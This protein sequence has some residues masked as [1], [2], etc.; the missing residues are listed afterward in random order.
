MAT[1]TKHR[2]QEE[3]IWDF[4]EVKTDDLTLSK[5]VIPQGL[6][7]ILVAH[8]GKVGSG[9]IWDSTEK[10]RVWTH[11]QPPLKFIAVKFRRFVRRYTLNEKDKKVYYDTTSF[12][13]GV[14][15]R[16]T[17]G[18]QGESLINEE[19]LEFQIHL[20]KDL[21]KGIKFPT[22]IEFKSFGLRIGKGLISSCVKAVSM[23]KTPASVMFGL[24]TENISY[25]T[26]EGQNTKFDI[27]KITKFNEKVK[28]DHIDT[29]FKTNSQKL[30]T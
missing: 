7:E 28:L 25:T 4:G 5:L 24:E 27:W 22:L 14:F 6:S 21:E 26:K 9:D 20:I 19:I 17:V 1:I 29:A 12:P 2:T 8:R 3:A 15:E 18:P 13:Q 23:G 11:G 10:E 16:E 30:L